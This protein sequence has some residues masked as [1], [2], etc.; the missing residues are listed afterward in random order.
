M[1]AILYLAKGGCQWRMFPK[2]FPPL[3]TVQGYFYDWRN[4]GLF[5]V[6]HLDIKLPGRFDRVG[7]HITAERKG[8]SNSRGIGL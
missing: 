8:Q 3:L 4:R 6:I 1:N 7:H 5:Q 2:D